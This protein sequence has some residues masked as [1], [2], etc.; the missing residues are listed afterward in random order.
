MLH[1]RPCDEPDGTASAAKLAKSFWNRQIF[2]NSRPAEPNQIL[3]GKIK[4][5]LAS[6]LE[7]KAMPFKIKMNYKGA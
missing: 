3:A 1:Q 2:F 5:K 7:T 4:F 6:V